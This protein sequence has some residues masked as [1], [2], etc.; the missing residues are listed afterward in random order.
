MKHT[1]IVELGDYRKNILRWLL[2]RHS[3]FVQ[4][5]YIWSRRRRSVPFSIP[6]TESGIFCNI[7]GSILCSV[8]YCKSSDLSAFQIENANKSERM[9]PAKNEIRQIALRFIRVHPTIEYSSVQTF[10]SV[11]RTA[12]IHQCLPLSQQRMA[13]RLRC[14][15][16]EL[17]DSAAKWHVES[18]NFEKFVNGNLLNSSVQVLNMRGT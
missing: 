5:K 10:L 6:T 1:R 17:T 13:L 18:H 4:F 8:T 14:N 3:V 7:C 12:H 2:H 11:T 9:E 16:M 15:H